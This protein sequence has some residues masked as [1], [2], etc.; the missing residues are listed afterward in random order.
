MADTIDK[1]Y[2]IDEDN[3]NLGYAGFALQKRTKICFTV[4]FFPA[5]TIKFAPQAKKSRG[6]VQPPTR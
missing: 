3:Y 2:R 1:N 5:L 6:A 4:I